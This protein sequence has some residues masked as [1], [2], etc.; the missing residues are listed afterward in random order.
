MRRVA[1]NVLKNYV[2]DYVSLFESDTDDEEQKAYD[3]SMLK[4]M[5]FEKLIREF[6]YEMFYEGTEFHYRKKETV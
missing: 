1:C 4:E 6:G 3:L 5:A 2:D